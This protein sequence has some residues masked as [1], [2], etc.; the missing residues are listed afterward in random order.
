MNKRMKK[1]HLLEKEIV[2]LKQ[3]MEEVF[4]KVTV[5]EEAYEQLKIENAKISKC[6]H[7]FQKPFW[8]RS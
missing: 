8:R 4:T 5:L 3:K 6:I 7:K 1:K 2:E